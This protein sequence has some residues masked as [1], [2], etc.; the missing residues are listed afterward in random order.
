MR[1]LSEV[2]NEARRVHAERE[3]RAEWAG[4][5]LSEIH[6]NAELIARTR[7]LILRGVD[8]RAAMHEACAGPVRVSEDPRPFKAPGER[9]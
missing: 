6:A 7:A 2:A 1:S 8:L 5:L 4:E 9:W 3:A